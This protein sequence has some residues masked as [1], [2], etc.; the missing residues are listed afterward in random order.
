MSFS[1]DDAPSRPE[2]EQW[3]GNQYTNQADSL[4]GQGYNYL[5]QYLPQVNTFSPELQNTYQGIA[6]QYT[7]SQWN[8]LNRGYTEAMNKM[9]QRNYNRFG[10]TNATGSLYDT[11]SL[12]RNYND[13]ASRIASNTA[14]MYNDLIN[15]EYNRRYNTLQFM[16]KLYNT[17]G[18]I[19]RDRDIGNWQIRNQNLTN[20]YLDQV[21]AYNNK[22]TAL[23]FIGDTLSG[24]AMGF[25]N[26]GSPWG[27][28]AGGVGSGLSSLGN[29]NYF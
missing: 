2:Y 14:S 3:Q 11:Q 15:N 13:L 20:D 21:D 1:K 4:V 19:T 17:A 6:N 18:Q 26:T 16:N 5:Q 7:Q 29:R 9:N 23:G 28:L 27:A 25:A 10:T 8:D 24:A 22:G 12:Q